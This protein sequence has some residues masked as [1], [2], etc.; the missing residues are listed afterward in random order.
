MKN[1]SAKA[2]VG[3]ARSTN[4][5]IRSGKDWMELLFGWWYR[6]T[7]PVRIAPNPRFARREIERRARLLSTL[8]FFLMIIAVLFLPAQLLDN[9]PGEALNTVV[10]TSIV[11]GGLL[12]NRAGRIVTAAL[13]IVAT[14]QIGMISLI[15]QPTL[16][17]L[18]PPVL[19][20]YDSLV[21]TELVAVSLLPTISIFVM[22]TINSTFIAI[23]LLYAPR[24]SQMEPILHGDLSQ[25][26]LRPIAL[27][28]FV[29]VVVALWVYSASRSN[30]R[31]NRAEIVAVLE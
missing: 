30:E 8:G 3:Q 22:A 11:I 14:V 1:T 6:F 28:F 29:A 24:T 21:L 10:G 12:L 23:H 31:A 16:T 2:N 15:L 17:P 18:V 5:L 9:S 13:I 20:T 19:Q 26:L 4:E 25:W 27:Q 7:T